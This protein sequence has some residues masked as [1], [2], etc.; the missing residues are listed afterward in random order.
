[1][2]RCIVT[3]GA[4]GANWGDLRRRERLVAALSP[5]ASRGAVC[6]RLSSQRTKKGKWAEAEMVVETISGWGFC[7]CVCFWDR[8]C[9]NF[10][11]PYLTVN[12]KHDQHG[13]EQ[14]GPERGDRQLG[15][16]FGVRQESQSRTYS[17]GERR[18]EETFC[19]WSLSTPSAPFKMPAVCA[20][21]LLLCCCCWYAGCTRTK[22][23]KQQPCNFFGDAFCLA[24]HF[25][26]KMEAN[27]M[28]ALHQCGFFG[29]L[30]PGGVQ[31]STKG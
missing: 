8:A 10:P 2:N 16:R 27:C 19:Q 23:K 31:R 12:P 1:M 28:A 25:Q 18:G 7:V 20:H 3:K 22:K 14:N 26:A 13:E 4:L 29:W 17:I 15:H 24:A 11:H 30:A 6:A 5:L 21:L 9:I